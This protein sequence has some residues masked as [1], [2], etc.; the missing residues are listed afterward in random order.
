SRQREGRMRRVM[1]INRSAERAYIAGVMV[2]VSAAVSPTSKER[3]CPSSHRAAPRSA[4]VDCPVVAARN[5]PT[6]RRWSSRNRKNVDDT[7]HRGVTIESRGASPHDFDFA[8]CRERDHIPAHNTGTKCAEWNAVQKDSGA[9]RLAATIAST[10]DQ[11]W[12]ITH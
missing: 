3:R 8:H 1:E 10:H 11:S 9:F 12:L 4:P 2:T 5:S 7:S 6:Q